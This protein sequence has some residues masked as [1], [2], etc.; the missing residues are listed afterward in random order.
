MDSINLK[1]LNDFIVK[2]K[3]VSYVG[4]GQ[5]LLPSRPGSHDLQFGEGNW[6]YH[7]CYFGSSDFIGEEAVYFKHRIIW[8]MNYYGRIIGP[9]MITAEEAGKIIMA[10]LSK[11]YLEGRFLGGFKHV[12]RDYV[13][14]DTNQGDIASF[15][16]R[17]WIDLNGKT[18]YELQYHGGLIRE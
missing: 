4:G 14:F 8:I 16:G 11:M 5:K 12:E 2:A 10:S 15:T 17:E 1:D 3:S 18:V 6:N 13:Y 7:D 9:A